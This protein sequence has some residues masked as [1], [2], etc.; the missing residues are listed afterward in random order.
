MYLL[1]QKNENAW[2]PLGTPLTTP[3]RIGYCIYLG[4]SV[5]FDDV[6]EVVFWVVEEQPHLPVCVGQENPLQV[7]HV[8][9]LQLS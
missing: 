4:S 8:G 7:D 9:V 1:F 5:E 3:N 6:P 2:A